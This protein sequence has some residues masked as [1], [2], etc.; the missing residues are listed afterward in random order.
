MRAALAIT[1]MVF[2]L[3]VGPAIIV[4]AQ[5]ESSRP[6]YCITEGWHF[7]AGPVRDQVIAQCLGKVRS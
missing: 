2:G 5:S 6:Q 3:L 7:D 1:G 4:G